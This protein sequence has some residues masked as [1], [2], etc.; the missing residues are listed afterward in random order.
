MTRR[1]LEGA[2]NHF[3]TILFVAAGTEKFQIDEFVD[4][5]HTRTAIALCREERHLGCTCASKRRRV[6]G[7]LNERSSRVRQRHPAAKHGAET[8]QFLPRLRPFNVADLQ[9]Q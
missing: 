6:E 2:D 1:V 8:P 7:L 4:Y 3:C 9:S 5:M